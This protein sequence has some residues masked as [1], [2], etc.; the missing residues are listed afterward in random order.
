MKDWFVEVVQIIVFPAVLFLQVANHETH[1]QKRK[2]DS[3]QSVYQ[4]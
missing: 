4:A 3:F 2:G 1:Q